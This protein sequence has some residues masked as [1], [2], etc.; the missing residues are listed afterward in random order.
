M[1]GQAARLAQALRDSP[2]EPP[3]STCPA[4]RGPKPMGSGVCRPC[5]GRQS[6]FI[7]HGTFKDQACSTCHV[8]RARGSSGLCRRCYERAW[9][10]KW[11]RTRRLKGVCLTLAGMPFDDLLRGVQ[12]RH[13]T[14]LE[15][16]QR[17]LEAVAE[18]QGWIARS[19]WPARRRPAG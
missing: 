14:A 9:N 19:P 3:P 8:Q 12:Q 11:A 17:L 5:A 15:A 7:R 16:A 18:G 13:P 10:R 4:C 2:E 6:A 1:I